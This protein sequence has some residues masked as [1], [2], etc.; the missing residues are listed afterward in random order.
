[1]S[2]EIMSIEHDDETC[3]RLEGDTGDTA[4]Q[5]FLSSLLAQPTSE[6]CSGIKSEEFE[7]FRKCPSSRCPSLLS[8]PKLPNN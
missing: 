5:F 4:D 7:E 2:D 6:H 1:M 3:Y 8:G